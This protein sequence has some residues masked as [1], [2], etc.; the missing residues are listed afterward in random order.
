MI[1]IE[2]ED[3]TTAFWTLSDIDLD[4]VAEWIE[5]NIK[6]ADSVGG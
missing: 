4:R 3:G 1:G 5:H 2:W 6:Q